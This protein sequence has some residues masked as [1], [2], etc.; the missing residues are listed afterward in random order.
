MEDVCTWWHFKLYACSIRS[1]TII[2]KYSILEHINFLNLCCSLEYI[3]IKNISARLYQFLYGRDRWFW[4]SSREE[5]AREAVQ[6]QSWRIREGL[7]WPGSVP[8]E[9]EHISLLTPSEL[10]FFQLMAGLGG[11]TG[12][13]F[14]HHMLGSDISSSLGSVYPMAKDASSPS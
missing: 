6:R 3:N 10:S 11:L 2:I 14:S 9:D 1:F 13:R 7:C 4:R 5:G 8:H 12:A